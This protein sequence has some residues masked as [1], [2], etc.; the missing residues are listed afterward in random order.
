MFGRKS[1]SRENKKKMEKE[2]QRERTIRQRQKQ[3]AQQ[4]LMFDTIY[5]N[6]ICKID[7]KRY[8]KTVE[9]S[10]VNYRLARKEDKEQ[11]FTSYCAFLNY[12]D[13]QVE[14]SL[15]FMN[16]VGGNL[17]LS[18]KVR[19]EQQADRFNDIREEYSAMLQDQLS[20]G[21]NGVRRRKFLTFTIKSDGY[22][23]SVPIL[24]RIQM[25]IM[26]NFAVLGVKCQ[27]LDR[28]ELVS[29]LR[30]MC[31]LGS[32]T[33][34]RF[35]DDFL[36]GGNTEKDFISPDYINLK[37]PKYIE[38]G[39]KLFARTSYLNIVAPELTDSFLAEILDIDSNLIVSLHIEPINRFRAL[40][41]IKGKLTDLEKMKIDE[42]KK[43]IRVGYDMDI[44]PPDLRTL[45][46]ESDMLLERVERENEQ[47]FYLSFLICNFAESPEELT[48]EV[49]KMEGVIR[50]QVCEL[51]PLHYQQEMAFNSIL[52][53]GRNLISMDRM[54]TTSSLA[55][56]IPFTTQ[57]LFD[58]SPESMYYGL[59]GL[60]STVIFADRKRLRSPNGLILGT[61]GSGK[62]FAA[63]RE[64]AN[65]F[66]VTDDDIIIVDPEAEYEPLVSALGGINLQIS[67]NSKNHINPLE[68]SLDVA[69]EDNPDPIRTKAEFI[70]SLFE[71]IMNVKN[72]LSGLE[73]SIIDRC[74][75]LVY[76]HYLNQPTPDNMPILE[77][78]YNILLAQKDPTANRLAQTLEIYVHG[79]LN[80]FNHR[81]NIYN[82][83]RIMNFVIKDLGEVLKKMA[84]LIVQDTIWGKVAVNKSQLRSTRYYIDEF[85]L[86]LKDKQTASYF[87]NNWKRLRKWN[88]I[89]TGITQN[90]KDFL[91]SPEIENIFDNTDFFLLLNQNSGDQEILAK[92]LKIS[93]QQISFVENAGAGEGLIIY[94]GTI[95]PFR[96]HFPKDTKLYALMTTK[97]SD[98]R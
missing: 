94:D 37:N 88:G 73:I 50:K 11:I 97:P 40:K 72:G 85:H 16:E 75:Q 42:N 5:K 89:P 6:G 79:S 87:V 27:P 24:E 95:I 86:L 14:L 66:L 30:K 71:I 29:L 81:T 64:I 57:E 51:R 68:I 8:S 34:L 74:V 82:N 91:Q 56:F 92:R 77:D 3:S 36:S 23:D 98:L 7:R 9:F 69:D 2:Q 63:K 67:A 61:T 43:V 44:L 12:F 62:S 49:K 38:L 93:R 46:E 84:M 17:Y 54:L 39:D 80:V 21:N 96:D 25:D 53:I 41:F 18:E 20:K 55:I 28:T 15:T 70:L 19:I 22:E 45:Q 65:C 48:E 59:N 10:D 31:R 4:S 58:I 33:G 35:Y 60:S 1:G 83:A 90:V 13:D 52:P 47:M 76:R 32:D 78:L 26:N